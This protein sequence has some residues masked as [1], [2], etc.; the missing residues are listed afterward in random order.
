MVATIPVRHAMSVQSPTPK[1][2]STAKQ[3]SQG[4][5]TLWLG[6]TM[7]TMGR[8]WKMGAE[9]HPSRWSRLA[10]LPGMALYNSTMAMIENLRFRKT[11]E[12]TQID[13]PPVFVLGHWRSGSTLLHNLL[14]SDPQFTYVNM[15]QT[16]FPSHFLTTERYGS[17]LGSPFL[18]KTRPMDNMECRFDLPQ[19]D[20]F[21]LCVMTG[22]SPYLLPIFQHQPR[23]ID[24]FF[25]VE[26]GLNPQ[27]LQEWKDALMLLMK[28]VTLKT[29]KPIVLK[30]PSHTFRTKLLLEMFP[31]AKFVYIYRNPYA[32]L[33]S[34]VHFRKTIFEE[35][36]LGKSQSEDMTE[37]V[38]QIYENCFYTYE[39]DRQL[40]P[41]GNLHEICFESLEADPLGEMQKLYAG[42][43]MPGFE[44]LKT[45]LEPQ[46]DSLRRYKKNKFTDDP[47]VM[48]RL[49]NRLKFAFDRYGYAPPH[50]DAETA[51][52]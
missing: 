11:L 13:Q 29:G 20:E 7:S 34:S 21:A 23:K 14:T 40:V 33:K 51:A 35:N 27:E 43:N 8:V 22:Y 2:E 32:V 30:S 36:A 42:L 15:Y 4:L 47:V 9:V 17:V 38:L 6:L 52:A 44:G 39:R 19:E 41:A 48:E 31:N 1:V 10:I 3:S 46:V 37:E 12:Q 18:P 5:I 28:K 25:N 26:E 24:R 50:L 45:V 49:Y 16:M